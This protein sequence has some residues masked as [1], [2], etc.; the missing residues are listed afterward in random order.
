MRLPRGRP[1]P[2]PPEKLRNRRGRHPA[3]T[4]PAARRPRRPH[5]HRRH[6]PPPPRGRSRGPP[7]STGPGRGHQARDR[8]GADRRAVSHLSPPRVGSRSLDSRE[9]LGRTH[10]LVR[11]GA[12]IAPRPPGGPAI[13]RA[14]APVPPGRGR[15]RD[16]GLP[17]AA[18]GDHNDGS[19]PALAPAGRETMPT[20][21][22]E[23][24]PARPASDR[25]TA[26]PWRDYSPSTRSRFGRWVD[27][28]LG[29]RLRGAGLCRRTWC[30]RSILQAEVRLDHYSER[31]GHGV[32][33]L[34]PA[35]GRPTID[36]RP[37]PPPR[38]RDARRRP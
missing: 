36:R 25:A 34:G 38:G 8:P 12:K 16:R 13:L 23:P 33:R 5:H 4:T 15:A 27:R 24:R 11:T 22:S 26:R 1:H 14:A 30:R 6:H 31:P 29:P 7:P 9:G 18:S 19:K 2:G 17:A 37:P 20:E 3:A 32:R 35:L 21:E 10:P 28:R